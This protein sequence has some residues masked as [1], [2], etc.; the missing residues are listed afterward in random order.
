MFW[1]AF[2]MTPCRSVSLFFCFW[3]FYLFI[4]EREWERSRDT[5]RGRSRLHA[6]SPMWDSIPG[7]WDHSLSWRQMLKRW[8]TQGSPIRTYVKDMIYFF[9]KILFM[10]SWVTQRE[11]GT[12]AEREAGSM[13]RAWCRTESQDSRITP[14]TKGR[15]STTESPRCPLDFLICLFIKAFL[16]IICHVLHKFLLVSCLSLT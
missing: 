10:Y 16:Y 12:L 8:A 7:S 1:M 6:G 4:H 11:A 9:L 15:C 14:W 5:D 3:R 13:Q 2:N